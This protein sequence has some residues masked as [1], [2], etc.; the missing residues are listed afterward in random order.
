[1][2]TGVG[3][4]GRIR[5]VYADGDTEAVSEESLYP[6]S[7]APGMRVE[8]RIRTWRQ[9]FPGEVQR[10][11]GHAVFVRFD[12][13]DEQWTSIGLVRV[14]IGDVSRDAPVAPVA[15]PTVPVPQPGSRVVANYRGEGW[16]YP[17]V[18]A[19]TRDDGQV[20]VIYADGDSEWRPTSDVRAD[21]VATGAD[22]QAR[23][24]RQAQ[25]HEGE[26]VRRV[27][28]AVELQLEDGAKQWVA[29]SNVR[30]R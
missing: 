22:V 28:H 14:P 6:D 21:P 11:V 30:V 10:R 25:V 5:V 26:V 9:W 13:G 23:P 29:L 16:F 8:A 3:T 27:G 24:A 19:E 17:A 20:H 15:P 4:D 12:D 7:I 2:V 18:V 1:V